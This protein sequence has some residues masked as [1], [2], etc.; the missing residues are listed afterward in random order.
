MSVV[1]NE[2]ADIYRTCLD[3]DIMVTGQCPQ[4]ATVLLGGPGG[5]A[6]THFEEMLASKHMRTRVFDADAIPQSTMFEHLDELCILTPHR[7]EFERV[8]GPVGSDVEIAAKTA[9]KSSGAIIV[10]KGSQTVIAH[11][12]GTMVRNIHASSYLAKAGTGDVLAGLIAGLVSQNMSPFQ[13]CCAAVWI[14]GEAGRQIGPGLI[15][16]DISDTVPIIL[17]ALLSSA[18]EE[19]Q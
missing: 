15:A 8:F 4:K 14:H 6:Q 10:L 13:A 3:P 17:Q 18:G 1:A 2:R 11:P 9:A 12:N 7:G 5:I 16:G 19:A